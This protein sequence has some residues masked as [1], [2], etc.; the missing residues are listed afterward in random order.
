MGMPIQMS[1]D[2]C[3]TKTSWKLLLSQQL[4]WSGHTGLPSDSAP[5]VTFPLLWSLFP[6]ITFFLLSVQVSFNYMYLQPLP[7]STVVHFSSAVIYPPHPTSPI[8]IIVI[9]VIMSTN[10]TCRPSTSSWRWALLLDMCGI[11]WVVNC[12]FF[13]SILKILSSM[14]ITTQVT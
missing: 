1:L 8:L 11:G 2:N 3:K 13:Q 5:K 7:T 10:C 14:N 6:P 12:I 9:I 4:L